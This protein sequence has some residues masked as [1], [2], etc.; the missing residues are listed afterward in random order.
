LWY[1][2]TFVINI[3]HLEIRTLSPVN[4][5]AETQG[6][7]GLPVRGVMN[8]YSDKSS[9]AATDPAI[10]PEESAHEELNLSYTSDS[11]QKILDYRVVEILLTTA[12]FGVIVLLRFHR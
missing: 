6:N 12:F 5:F 8:V 7:L 4:R 10:R 1:G 11:Y 9:S 2:G 3:K